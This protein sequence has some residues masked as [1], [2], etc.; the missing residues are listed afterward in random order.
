MTAPA[1]PSGSSAGGVSAAPAQR[2]W[3]RPRAAAVWAPLVLALLVM[4]IPTFY[5]M[6]TG[7][8]ATEE[9]AHGPIILGISLWLIY[10]NWGPMLDASEGATRSWLGWPVLLLSCALY[11]LGRSQNIALFEV[12]SF[13]GA[14]VGL[15][16][17]TRGPQALR[18]QWFPF[19]FML[20]MLPLP[21]SLV[22]ML[23]LPMKTAVSYLVDKLLY[24]LG[25]PISRTGVIL[26]IGQYQLLVADACAGLHTL[27]TLEALGLLYL[28]VVRHNSLL[29]NV[30]LAILIVPISFISNVI[31][32]VVLTLVTYHFGDAAGQ[33][34]LHGFAGMVLFVSALMLI[35][36]ADSLL[37]FG[38]A[39][40]GIP[41]FQRAP[42]AT[43][44]LGA[45]PFGPL[46]ATLP[47]ALVM[48][49]AVLG[50]VLIKPEKMLADTAPAIILD[51]S[52][53]LAFGRWRLDPDTVALVPSSVKQE[54]ISQIYS[55]TLSRTYVNPA[56]ERV[57]LAIAYGSNQTRQL[58]A[59][60]QEVC[61]VAQGFQIDTLQ[62]GQLQVAGASVPVTRMV[63][64]N[65]PRIEPVTYWFTMGS[66]VVRSY[67]DRQLVEL[68]YALSD[69]IP[70]GYLF[71]VSTVGADAG[72]AFTLQA[73]FVD[74]LMDA[75]DPVVRA[76]L[77]G[78][79]AAGANAG[80][81]AAARLDVN[82]GASLAA[83][84]A[85]NS[86]AR[87]PVSPALNKVANAG[88]MRAQS[89]PAK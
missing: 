89:E 72:Q 4:Y 74:E 25:Y 24:A 22:D 67:L 78:G 56:G 5:D 40:P 30:M 82:A 65:G 6:F 63:A 60:R 69:L 45:R 81:N 39:E 13:L 14:G 58:R 62:S 19:F 37:R 17:L 16:L 1:M 35:I 52:V 75:L 42:R 49:A 47:A 79:A 55:Q 7:P 43:R 73:A 32:V 76:R 23:T 68:K 15:L 86:A 2:P 11:F 34:F 36:G 9:Q 85:A 54:A 59:H 18:A 88:A 46:G 70:D 77:L 84:S 87:A 27:F 12:G 26:Q 21:G 33:G 83:D 53:P 48:A 80:A 44:A 51:T 8:W 28:N 61:Y 41:L 20:F 64:S 10:R 38:V 31:R 57:M 50:T 3:L 71:R 66:S 29:R